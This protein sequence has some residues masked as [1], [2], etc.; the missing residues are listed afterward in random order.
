MDMSVSPGERGQ[1]AG[2]MLSGWW[3][4]KGGVSPAQLAPLAATGLAWY[5]LNRR[6]TNMCCFDVKSP[7]FCK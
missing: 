7:Q 6:F 4:G 3:A 2:A 5:S 1:Q